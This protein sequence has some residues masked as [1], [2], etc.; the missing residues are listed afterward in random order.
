M[1]VVVGFLRAQTQLNDAVSILHSF[2][3]LLEL[4][5]VPSLVR[6]VSTA[7]AAAAAAAAVVDDGNDGSPYFDVVAV[8]ADHYYYQKGDTSL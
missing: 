7:T 8:A 6:R 2:H 3:C 5:R 4:I 1:V